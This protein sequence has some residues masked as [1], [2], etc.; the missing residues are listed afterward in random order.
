VNETKF[1]KNSLRTL[2]EKVFTGMQKEQELLANKDALGLQQQAKAKLDVLNAI[3]T[4][5]S[6]VMKV[7]F[8]DRASVLSSLTKAY[9]QTVENAMLFIENLIG[10]AKKNQENINKSK[11]GQEQFLQGLIALKELKDPINERSGAFDST[12]LKRTDYVS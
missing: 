11:E 10:D 7:Q 3:S 2:D 4:E 5:F 8:G 12:K 6:N 9:T 1:I